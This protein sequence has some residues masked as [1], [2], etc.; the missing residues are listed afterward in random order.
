MAMNGLT[1]IFVDAG[2][3]VS[4]SAHAWATWEYSAKGEKSLATTN[5]N[6]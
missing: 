2:C 5:R 3:A 6:S 1:K 4:T